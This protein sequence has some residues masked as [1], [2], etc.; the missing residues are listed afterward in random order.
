MVDPSF[1]V[2]KSSHPLPAFSVSAS[3]FPATVTL[4]LLLSLTVG[5]NET[6]QAYLAA[7]PDKAEMVAG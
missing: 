5:G 4:T 7:H 6:V 1:S 2:L 3:V